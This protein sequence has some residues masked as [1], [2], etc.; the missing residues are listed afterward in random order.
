M[1]LTCQAC[2]QKNRVPADKL[3][4][5]GR[6]GQCKAALASPQQSITIQDEAAFDEIIQHAH[7]PVLVDFWAPWCG[8]CKMA[9]PHLEQVAKQHQGRALVLKV[10]TDEQPGLASRYQVRGI[11]HFVVLDKGAVVKQQSGVVPAQV[12]SQWLDAARA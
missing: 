11:P 7:V 9:A 10:N 12:M 8:P 2:G 5:G 3:T 1:I 6:C 4:D